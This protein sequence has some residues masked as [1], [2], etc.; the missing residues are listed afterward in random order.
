MPVLSHQAAA[1]SAPLSQRLQAVTEAL[2]ATHHQSD[3]LGI[4]LIPAL[5]A[6]QASAG[7]V[8][9][10]DSASV[11]LELAAAQGYPSDAQNPWREGGLLNGAGP[12]GDA[13][14]RHE[15]LFFEHP[16]ALLQ[17]YPEWAGR[18]EGVT[19][20]A[21]AVLPMVLDH[22]P[23]GALIVEFNEPHHFTEAEIPFLRT[24]AAQCAVALGRAELNKTLEARVAARTIE[25]EG[26][27]AALDAFV[28]YK[29]AVG[30]E[31]DVLTLVR[32]AVQVVHANLLHVSVAYYELEDGL[33][34]ARVWSEDVSPEVAA[35]IQAGVPAD[36]PDFSQAAHSRAAV[37]VDGWEAEVNG[38][39]ST[40][41]Y[42]AVALLPLVVNGQTRS[43]FAVGTREA[44]AWVEREKALVRAVARGLSITLERTEITRQLQTQNAELDARAQALQAFAQLT[45]D[46]ATQSDPYQFVRRAQEVM[47]SLLT[48]G[49]ALYYERDG[50]HW[51][52][53]VQVGQVGHADLQAFID[54]GPLVGATPTVDVPWTTQ[55]P[56]YQDDY[57]RGSDTPAEMVQHVT[58]AASLPVFR[59]GAVVGVLVAVLFD[60]RRWTSTDQVVLETVVGS[61]S[62]ALERAEQAGELQQRT[63]ELERSNAE[64]EQFAH[65]ASHDL[66]V[67]IRAV[68]SFAGIIKRR[69]QAELDTRG[70]LYLQQI[71]DN[72]EHMKRLVDDLLTLSSVGTRQREHQQVQVE[73]VVDAVVSRLQVENLE[74]R[75]TRTALPAVQADPQQLDQLFQN[76]ISNALKYR[77]DE[78]IPQVR[79]SAGRDGPMWRFAVA[80][81]GIGIEAA[82]FERIFEIFQRLHGR[83]TF[84]GTGIGLAVC[85]KIV[86]RHGG[87]LW[88]ESTP[89]QG[90]TF[91]F[92]IPMGEHGRT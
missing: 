85:K 33:W 35:E 60:A 22:R 64:L 18:T 71:I 19:A 40:T 70:Q 4:V 12:A 21:T 83:E 17:A 41:A 82:Y 79:V 44:H 59:R 81:N 29:E 28:A 38:L 2:A 61:L 62:L 1:G 34:K 5:H 11:G 24:L 25:L 32:Q 7:A 36:A 52:N 10:A 48:P 6:L 68:T 53:R 30:S 50:Q 55:R 57:V 56:H 67:P 8:L 91:F 51:R 43:L 63:R 37:F 88:L 9:L 92:T 46:M 78:V 86:E 20:G 75:I 72:G 27:R 31:S 14:Q 15:P 13:L 74:A 42:G 45:Q 89:G 23:L 87:H 54:A 66:Q 90:T 69:Y 84:E 76:L 47:L 73:T 49:Y 65:V 39:P 26:E 16:G 3:V 77:R 58:T 80:D